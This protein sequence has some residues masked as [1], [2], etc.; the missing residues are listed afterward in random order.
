MSR[1]SYHYHYAFNCTQL[2]MRSVDALHA[3]I[4]QAVDITYA[5]FRKH[6][7]GLDEWAERM[8]YVTH[9]PGLRLKDDFHVSYHRSRW[10]GQRCYYIR[11]SA[12]EH[13]WLPKE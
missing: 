5:T 11:H 12:I 7:V 3:M 8:G 13:V 4:D 9:G 10:K 2:S 1:S 6:A